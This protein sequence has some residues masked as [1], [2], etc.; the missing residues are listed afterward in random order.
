MSSAQP[1]PVQEELDELVRDAVKIVFDI[2]P[3]GW[4]WLRLMTGTSLA[5]FGGVVTL[6]AIDMLRSNPT[7]DPMIGWFAGLSALAALGGLGLAGPVLF[8]NVCLNVAYVRLARRHKRLRRQLP[9]ADRGLPLV[10]LAWGMSVWE[11]RERWIVGVVGLV[12]VVVFQVTAP[13]R[14]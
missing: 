14:Y 3:D 13:D 7:V 4:A 6:V 5:L 2:H 8:R 9:P 10:S 12:L 1:R 11:V